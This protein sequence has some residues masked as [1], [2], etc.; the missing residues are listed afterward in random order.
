MLP[1]G[2][3]EAA[4]IGIEGD[5]KAATGRR[6]KAEGREKRKAAAGGIELAIWVRF[7]EGGGFAGQPERGPG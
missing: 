4:V 2:S 1:Q 6:R 7:T 5:A 3:A